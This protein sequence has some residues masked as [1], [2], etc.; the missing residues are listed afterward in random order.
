MTESIATSGKAQ[1]EW[2][3]FIQKATK[4]CVVFLLFDHA[5]TLQVVGEEAQSSRLLLCEAARKAG[6][7]L[8]CLLA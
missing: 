8:G 7:L 2:G 1:K 5:H 3:S 6:C 4:S